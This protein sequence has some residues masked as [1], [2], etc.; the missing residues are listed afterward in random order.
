VLGAGLFT[1][2]KACLSFGTTATIN[3][4]TSKYRESFR[5]L[6]VPYPAAAPGLYNL[7]FQ[8]FRG[9]WL[10]RWFKEQFGFKE[11][12]LAQEKGIMA[13]KLLD[14]LVKECPPGALGLMVHPFWT[15]GV[16]YPGPE[17]KGAIIGFGDTHTRAHLYRAILE[18][19][20]Y[21]L[22]EGKE[23]IEEVARTPITQLVVAGGG[24]QSDAAMQITADIFGLP[25]ARPSIYETSS[26]GAAI[27]LAIGL[28]FYKNVAEAVKTMCKTGAVFEPDF[29]NHHL[30]N[31]LYRRVYKKF[32]KRLKPLYHELQEITDYPEKV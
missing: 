24:S 4:T 31:E 7:E 23:R 2:D 27:D 15:P 32:Y 28:G 30:Y 17:S 26:L 1:P 13:E 22:R 21:S 9:F 14:E 3:V 29:K 5:Y 8:I 19:L 6:S 11:E 16:L 25:A 20:I 18:G 10:V 12:L